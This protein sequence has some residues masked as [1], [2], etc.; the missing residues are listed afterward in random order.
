MGVNL[1]IQDDVLCGTPLW[2]DAAD[3][4][5]MAEPNPRCYVCSEVVIQHFKVLNMR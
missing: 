4:S 2:E 1:L 5:E 3:A